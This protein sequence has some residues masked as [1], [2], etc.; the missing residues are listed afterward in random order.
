MIAHRSLTITIAS[1]VLVGLF[2]LF[3]SW[4]MGPHHGDSHTC[5][6]AM[7]GT[8]ECP[9]TSN[10][11][12]QLFHVQ[13]FQR[14]ASS[15]LASAG[16]A[17]SVLSLLLIALFFHRLAAGVGKFVVFLPVFARVDS[18]PAPSDR[19]RWLAFH[20]HSPSAAP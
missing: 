7:A 13:A 19:A 18:P 17:L 10:V 6:A 3:S 9:N 5:L 15:Y 1:L 2:I 14:F 8:V 4:W 11:G 20:E 16:A 12:S